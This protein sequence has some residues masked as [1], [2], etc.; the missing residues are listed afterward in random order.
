[1]TAIPGIESLEEIGRGADSIV[2][3][4]RHGATP[5]AIKMSRLADAGDGVLRRRIR[6]EAALLGTVHHA[7]LPEVFA[8]GDSDG[9]PFLVRAYMEGRPVSEVLASGRLPESH[10]MMLALDVSSA[11][12]AVHRHGLV[13][14]DIT[15]ANLV[16][17]PDGRTRLIDFGLAGLPLSESL[18]VA[19]GT[20]LY[21]APEQTGFL[22]RPVDAR[23][24]LYS[25]G[26]V[27]FEALAGRPPFRAENP[28]EVLRLH[29]AVPAVDL[30]TLRP[31]VSPAM[32]LI[33]A[34]L[35]EKDPDD[36]YPSAR[37]LHSDLEILGSLNETLH[38]G[39]PIALA[40]TGFDPDDAGPVVGRE[41][42]LVALSTHWA[43]SRRGRGRTL[44][45]TGE[46]GLGKTRVL[47]GFLAAEEHETGAVGVRLFAR[48]AGVD[49]SAFGPLRR[50]VEAAVASI[51]PVGGASLNH[52][53]AAAADL[54]PLLATFS[55]ALAERLGATVPLYGAPELGE[56][57]SD[58]LLEFL[59]AW[60]RTASGLL[61]VVDDAHRLDEA[62][63]H[64]V[65]RLAAVAGRGPVMVVLAAPTAD[66]VRWVPANP[67][68]LTLGPLE[69]A[70]IERYLSGL[71]AIPKVD[72]ALVARLMT[73]SRGNP[74][75]LEEF[76]RALLDE[77]LLLPQWGEWT[78]DAAELNHVALPTDVME[79][80]VGRLE[81][82][83]PRTRRILD[84]ASVQGRRFRPERLAR[85]LDLP[86]E[87]V[88]EALGE[89]LGSWIVE[90][91]SDGA[92]GFIHERVQQALLDAL[93][94]DT[95]REWHQRT[96]DAL[97]AAGVPALAEDLFA[98][99]RHAA[100]GH[101]ERHPERVFALQLDAGR[102]AL[103]D[104]APEEA[105][106]LLVE[107]LESAETAGITAPLALHH[108]LGDAAARTGRLDEAQFHLDAA[109]AATEDRVERAAIHGRLAEAALTRSDV[110]LAQ[111][112]L[113]RGLLAL[114]A[115]T[116]PL[117][118]LG[119]VGLLLRDAFAGRLWR[120][121]GARP[122]VEVETL[123][124]LLHFRTYATLFEMNSVALADVILRQRWA[125]RSLDSRHPAWILAECHRAILE[126]VRGR[127]LPALAH[128]RR[129]VMAAERMG[130]PQIIA[131]AHIHEAWTVHFVGRSIEAA[132][133]AADCL[134]ARGHWLDAF[135]YLNGCGDLAWNLY[136]RGYAT[137]ALTWVERGLNY[138][139]HASQRAN[140]I[141][142]NVFEALGAPIL[143]VL[144]RERESTEALERV[145]ERFGTLPVDRY[146][147]GALAVCEA[148]WYV[149]RRELDD[150]FEE[151]LSRF[152]GLGLQ[153]NEIMLHFR[154][155]YVA[156]ARG[157]F[158]QWRAS[159]KNETA[160]RRFWAALRALERAASIP[161]LSLHVH[162]L[163]A[164][165]ALLRGRSP[166]VPLQ[167]AAALS[168]EA[169]SPWGAFEVARLTA[170]SLQR[171]GPD[172]AMLREAHWAYQLAIDH[173]WADRARQIQAELGYAQGVT[174]P[175]ES[176][177]APSLLLRRQ[178]DALLEVA[179]ASAT[180]LD[181]ELQAR[182]V[183]DE[184]VR[185]LG[186]ERAFLLGP[187]HGASESD[188]P[189]PTMG[190]LSLVVRAGRD[191]HGREL[192]APADLHTAVIDRVVLTHLPLV[193]GGGAAPE[194]AD[195]QDEPRLPR[196]ALAAPLLLRDR[197]LGV[198]YADHRRVRGIFTADDAQILLAIAQHLAIALETA[199][200]TQLEVYRRIA[201]NV[202][203]TVFRLRRRIDA[204]LRFEYVS[205]AARGLLGVAP[206]ALLADAQLILAA[207]TVPDR[208]TLVETLA[209]S[210]R[211]LT[212]WRWEGR[213][214]DGTAWIE[215]VARP[216]RQH[217]G[218]VIWDGLLTDVTARKT[219][220][221]ETRALNTQL[222]HRVRTRTRE[223]AAANKELEAFNYSVS[224]DLRSAL[225]SVEGF[226]AMLHED[227]AERLG[228]AGREML[229]RIAEAA[230]RMWKV[231]DA[232]HDLSRL[233]RSEM[234]REPVDLAELARQ[235]IGD[236]RRQSPER[237]VVLGVQEPLMVDADAPLVL[238]VLE[239]LLGNAW[240][241]TGRRPLA[242]IDVGAGPTPS[243]LAYF[244]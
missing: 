123:S 34:R 194:N 193:H 207:F 28:A 192:G 106:R 116:R 134:K 179:L 233:N 201:A 78:L 99:A 234:H 50:A 126:A 52:L 238:V 138:E 218:D 155:F 200:H 240:K 110:A 75:A 14:R 142:G 82:L 121:R 176:Q 146:R 19:A 160:A 148:A 104:F 229:D 181:P 151:A 12:A 53:R 15:P 188:T 223:L 239:N 70:G 10:A 57:M 84:V 135:D 210:A 80:I 65:Q 191:A 61:L 29:A 153:P 174:G 203:G 69:A 45:L 47:R 38:A 141:L 91:E 51:P 27:L 102:R 7:G 86:P 13:H 130:D 2:Y 156:A 131:R 152:E 143:A 62:T 71:L 67:V 132:E 59:Q 226:S 137:E 145:R 136:V 244:V 190:H 215:G 8:T 161:V 33:V 221:V 159:P 17:G 6:R 46:A 92:Y 119:V 211:L 39:R 93:P 109:L 177:A 35:L 98:V 186:A 3:R 68:T 88:Y 79:L 24:D 183:L 157:R 241:F 4:G 237:E 40:R 94:K 242:R 235:I 118:L 197:L 222:E 44:L 163:K 81:R 182:R 9:R 63:R 202:P 97:L 180:V 216:E 120:S 95:Q 41:A 230:Q 22:K 178:R 150:G 228:D 198:V 168:Q 144:G 189:L 42:E 173:D 87:E 170:Q 236:L 60:A 185:L 115:R 89:A 83:Q 54:V 85:V 124:Q 147:L 172:A 26:A 103:R 113:D 32:A 11:L 158:E 5:V 31:E 219:A 111:S 48:G 196:S 125:V 217:G 90:R 122:T 36:R 165:A 184:T 209:E 129:A 18:I 66:S 37:S 43:E 166:Q 25:L 199:R 214:A 21:A 231:L 55:I 16:L 1:M 213:T 20:Y 100:R 167:R 212:P 107:A 73:H 49:A 220:E 114:G 127:T 72:P 195:T 117:G 56:R 133:R 205:E 204:R 154:L 171:S 96:A 58:A 149:E 164:A 206:D 140:R 64:V 76:V 112:A 139:S 108:A 30:R 105:W 175:F 101:R 162:L 225:R 128:A 243:G 74:F 169:D 227:F 232:L 208:T 77:G 187:H 224:H 23:S